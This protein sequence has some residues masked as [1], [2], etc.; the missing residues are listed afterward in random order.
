MKLKLI[1]TFL[2]LFAITGCGGSKSLDRTTSE[3]Q[4]HPD[5]PKYMSNRSAGR[6]QRHF[7]ENDIT[8]QNPN[9][10]DLSGTGSGSERGSNIGLDVDKAR[11]VVGQ[12]KDFKPGSVWINGNRMSVTVYKKGMKNEQDRRAAQTMIHRK[13][14]EALP[15]YTIDV[16][17]KEDRS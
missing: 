11:Q 4:K 1:L 2:V 9:F 10:L 3:L 15:G 16:T 6:E 14:I 13:L 8:N 7:V 12:T 17:V 5:T